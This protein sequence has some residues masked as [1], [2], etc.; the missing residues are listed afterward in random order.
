[1]NYLYHKLFYVQK[2]GTFLIKFFQF[3]LLSDTN[4]ST[5]INFDKF[6][7]LFLCYKIIKARSARDQV[8]IKMKIDEFPPT[9]L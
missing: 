6:M 3:F 4:F 8:W 1:M 9:R 5:K 2:Y 7:D